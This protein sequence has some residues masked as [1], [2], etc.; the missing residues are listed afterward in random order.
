MQASDTAEQGTY[1]ANTKFRHGSFDHS[2]FHA[3][4]TSETCT[5]S[6]FSSQ[7]HEMKGHIHMPKDGCKIL[8]SI[9]LTHHSTDLAAGLASRDATR[10]QLFKP[11]F[12]TAASYG[13]LARQE[14]CN[15][16]VH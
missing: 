12:M 10:G 5:A 2:E 6:G 14:G 7:L 11:Y 4:R 16:Q 1:A 15:G 3:I 9:L 13:R 8:N